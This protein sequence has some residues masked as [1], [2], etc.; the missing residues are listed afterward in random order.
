MLNCAGKDKAVALRWR[1]DKY[2]KDILANPWPID[3]LQQQLFGCV[4]LV[5]QHAGID[6]SSLLINK[7]RT[8]PELLRII[9][10]VEKVKDMLMLGFVTKM[11]EVYRIAPGS[12]FIEGKMEMEEDG[13]LD[14]D[15]ASLGDLGDQQV[16]LFETRVA[17]TAGIGIR[18]VDAEPPTS[19]FSERTAASLG[20]DLK[21]VVLVY[22]HQVVKQP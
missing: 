9:E 3:T 15:E 5:L 16:G 2:R 19:P 22:Q 12:P 18:Q 4:K 11:Y 7:I 8:G 17:C 10:S 20:L 14:G 6:P 21:P 13:M 1:A